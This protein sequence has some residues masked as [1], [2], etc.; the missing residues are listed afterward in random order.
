LIRALLLAA[1][2]VG[3]TAPMPHFPPCPPSVP[4]RLRPHEPL[5]PLEVRVE[6]AREAERARGNAGA[7]AVET[8]DAWIRNPK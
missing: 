8:R 6:L 4:A 5:V 1:L 7:V 3:C 2:L